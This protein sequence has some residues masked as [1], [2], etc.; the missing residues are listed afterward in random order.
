MLKKLTI[1][2]TFITIITL[3]A[4]LLFAVNSHGQVIGNST[5]F[6]LLV[7]VMYAALISSS[8]LL[9]YLNWQNN[10]KNWAFLFWANIIIVLIPTLLNISGLLK[11]PSAFL[12]LLDLYWLNKYLVYVATAYCLPILSFKRG[13]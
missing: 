12:I 11:L 13:A 1:F 2:V 8:L 7:N 5:S 9:G 6:G 4:T 3:N 10:Q